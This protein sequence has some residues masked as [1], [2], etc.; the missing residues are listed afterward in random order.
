MLL[1][2]GADV[3]SP[4][5]WALQTAAAQ[6]HINIVKLLLEHGANVNARISEDHFPQGTALQA[7]CEA[8]FGEIVNL[9]LEHHAD[10]NLGAGPLT[11]PIIAAASQGE[12]DILVQFIK[13]RAHLDIFSGPDN[14]S[15]LITAAS[16]LP[17]A[18][19]EALLDA[20]ATIDLADSDGDTALIIAAASG[21]AE[22]VQ[23]LLDRGADIMHVNAAGYNAL[24]RSI[25]SEN[26]DCVKLLVN[27]V[28]ADLVVL[29][30]AVDEANMEIARLVRDAAQIPASSEDVSHEDNQT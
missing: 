13:A 11:C 22:C 28:S 14:T 19:V 24:Q 7:A 3:D 2:H 26:E 20:G 5:G 15:P 8:G 1:A 29:K 21:D 9:L 12:A 23:L 17:V 10:P 4:N 6:G 30:T 16:M 25:E 27:C 18:S